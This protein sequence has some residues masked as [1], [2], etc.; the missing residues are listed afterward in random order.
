MLEVQ[1]QE[2]SCFKE[3]RSI[4]HDLLI[5]NHPSLS[6]LRPTSILETLYNTAVS[7]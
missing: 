3:L 4:L 2:G 7:Y 5:N 6:S 1:I